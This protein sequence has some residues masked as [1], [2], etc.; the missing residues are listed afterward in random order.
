MK[1]KIIIIILISLFL[2]SGCKLKDEDGAINDKA[3]EEIEFIENEDLS[4]VNKYIKG[5]YNDKYGLNWKNINNDAQKINGSME[6]IMIDLLEFKIKEEDLL[7]LRNNINDMLLAIGRENEKELIDTCAYLYTSLPGIL[8]NITNDNNQLNLLRFKSYIVLSFSKCIL[9]EWEEAKEIADLA[10]NKYNEMINNVDYLQ[11]S[12]YNL[13]RIYILLE[14]YKNGIELE[15]LEL[16]KNK[17]IE[18]IEGI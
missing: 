14:E 2:F 8:E 13:N 17:Y 10:E 7:T 9:L 1:R 3:L 5:E 18:F 15:E 6:T 4:I 11:N 12:S 16:V